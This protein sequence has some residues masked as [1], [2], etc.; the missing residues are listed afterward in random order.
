MSSSFEPETTEQ[1]SLGTLFTEM[2]SE[3]STLFRQEVSLAKAE[4]RQ[5]AS[6]AGQAAGLLAGAAIAG[7]VGLLILTMALAFAIGDLLEN[8]WLGFLIIGIILAIAAAVLAQS[9]RKRLQTVN[10]T[11]ER[12]IETLK[13]DMQTIKERRP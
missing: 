4:V 8:T 2:T 6:K 7:L 3:L 11:P 5:E 10:P 12:T 9:G 13:E 1:R